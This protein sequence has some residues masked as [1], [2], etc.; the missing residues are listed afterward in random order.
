[1]HSSDWATFFI[2]LFITE[3]GL[4]R[5][6]GFFP[7]QT[8]WTASGLRLNLK[9]L[10]WIAFHECTFNRIKKSALTEL[11]EMIWLI[12]H[13]NHYSAAGQKLV[14]WF[15]FSE[16]QASFRSLSLPPAS[17]LTQPIRRRCFDFISSKENMKWFVEYWLDY[18]DEVTCVVNIVN[19]HKPW[20]NS[21]AIFPIPFLLP[22]PALNR[23]INSLINL[24]NM[25]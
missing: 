7:G 18:M 3:P 16:C 1:M 13:W 9:K 6:T 25:K 11:H 21:I 14:T 5:S 10:Y 24:I 17:S 22:K 15:L 19:E 23:K 12:F 8:E 2:S 4:C 20:L